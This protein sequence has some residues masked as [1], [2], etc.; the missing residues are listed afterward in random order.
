MYGAID[1]TGAADGFVYHTDKS[2]NV[3]KFTPDQIA[4]LNGQF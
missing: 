3:F 4:Q 2:D 1:Y